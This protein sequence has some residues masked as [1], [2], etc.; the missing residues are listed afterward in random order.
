MFPWVV[1]LGGAAALNVALPDQ[2]PRRDGGSRYL[3]GRNSSK[4]VQYG[5]QNISVLGI[6]ANLFTD[7]DQEGDRVED[8]QTG[9]VLSD[10]VGTLKKVAVA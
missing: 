9:R 2:E 6:V 4:R 10:R 5:E 8:P 3:S 1:L 7:R